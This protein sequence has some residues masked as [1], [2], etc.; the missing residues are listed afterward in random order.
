MPGK[1]KEATEV[2]AH[3]VS[4]LMLAKKAR[5]IR[6]LDVRSVTPMTEFF[7]NCTSDSHPQ[8]KAISDHIEDELRKDG[9]KP[10]H[11]EGIEN[12]EWILMDYVNIIVNIFSQKSR[13]Y[14]QLE[15]LWGDAVITEIADED[16]A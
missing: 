12:R 2:I 5:N 11:I 15:R 3:K 1:K 6:I 10:W 9:V 16:T 13:E 4:D 14:Y 7:I 8:T